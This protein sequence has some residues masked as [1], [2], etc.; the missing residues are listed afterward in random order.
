MSVLTDTRRSRQQKTLTRACAHGSL[1]CAQVAG[2]GDVAYGA[3]PVSGTSMVKL[4][5]ATDGVLSKPGLV[6]PQYAELRTFTE[7]AAAAQD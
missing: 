2:G 5:S 7:P 1:P 6:L 4:M 3:N